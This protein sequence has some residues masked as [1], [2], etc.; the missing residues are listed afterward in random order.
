MVT[1][2][3]PN[4]IKHASNVTLT[5]TDLDLVKQVLFAGTATPVTEFISQSATSLIVKVPGETTK[6][7]ITVVAASGVSTSSGQELDLIMPVITSM[8]PNPIDAETNLTVTGT[9]LDLVKGISFVGGT[10]PITDFV[11]QSPSKIVV[12]V[13]KVTLK[14]KVSLSFLN[15]PLTVTSTDDLVLNGGLPPLADLPF[16][17]YTDATQNGF[18]DWSYTDTHDF[19]ST[20]NVRQGTKSVLATYNATNGYQG[21]TFHNDAGAAIP[22]YTKIEFSVFGE[23]GTAGKTLNVVVNKDYSHPI[24]VTIKEGEWSTYNVDLSQF[25]SPASLVEITLQSAGWVEPYMLI[26]WV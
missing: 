22:G 17:I 18:Q 10:E 23:A 11:S 24:G 19:N 7:M 5:G 1:T 4:P 14:C 20:S 15:S 6:G 25:G 16:P 26:M 12:K 2:V 13:P 3:S 21:L 8:S 9:N